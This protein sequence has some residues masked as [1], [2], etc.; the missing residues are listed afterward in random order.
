MDTYAQLQGSFSPQQEE[1]LR[2]L[3][4]EWSDLL[5]RE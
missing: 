2:R 4:A 1:D 5:A 3:R